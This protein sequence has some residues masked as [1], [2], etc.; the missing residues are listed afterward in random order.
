MKFIKAQKVLIGV[1]IAFAFACF[2]LTPS[3]AEG[4]AI[5]ISPVTESLQLTPGQSHAG[6]VLVRNIGDETLT[7]SVE[8]MPYQVTNGDYTPMYTTENNWTQ[9]TNWITVP[10][11]KFS[12]EPDKTQEIPY[13]ISVPVGAPGGGQYAVIM[14]SSDDGTK[15]GGTVKIVSNVGMIISAEVDGDIHRSGE[16]VSKNIQGF[17]LQPPLSANFTLSNTGNVSATASCVM[18]GTNFFNGSE[19]F[20]NAET[21]KKVAVLPDTIRN[22]EITWNNTPFLGVFRVAASVEYLND[23]A[24]FSK[25]VIVCPLWFILV[26]VGLIAAAVIYIVIKFKKRRERHSKKRFNF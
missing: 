5:E 10:N 20:S 19:V 13:S 23:T 18:K 25:V 2:G 1:F 22:S 12:L 6:T 7:F 11:G 14:I 26:I 9:I 16:I 4:G 21:P 8:V 3:F 24:N 17:L 15:S